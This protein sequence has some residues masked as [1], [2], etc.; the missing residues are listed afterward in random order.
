VSGSGRKRLYLLITITF[1]AAVLRGW[2]ALR[3]PTDF[4]EPVYLQ[5]AF[6]Y[7]RAIQEGDWRAVA[8]YAG[9][10]EHPALVKLLYGGVT[11]LLGPDP[12]WLAAGLANR[13][14]SALWGTVA[15]LVLSLLSPLA[16]G[17]LAAHTLTIKYTGQ[18]YLEALP[19][20]TSLVAVLAL[21]KAR[22][23]GSRWFW[24]SA[25]ALGATAAS[26]F[27]YLPVGL[28]ILY[29]ATWEKRWRWQHLLFYGAAAGA[30]FW[31]LN[32]TLWHDPL[33]RLLE[34]A[35]FHVRYS[36]GAHVQQVGYPWYQPLYW[37]SRSPP[38]LW[39]PEVFFYPGID[40]AV[41]LL[42][43]VGLNWEWK[44]RR[45]VVVWVLTSLLFLLLWPTKWPQYTLVLIPALCLS[46]G[47]AVYHGLTWLRRQ[48]TLLQWL[49]TMVPAPPRA[50]WYL[51][52][53][54]VLVIAAS[55]TVG[56]LQMTLGRL[57]WSQITAQNS[58][59]PSNLVHAIEL[60]PADQMVFATER[61][62]VMWPL[63]SATETTQNVAVWTTENSG[64]ISNRVRAVLCDQADRLWFGTEA[65]LSQLDGDVWTSFRGVDLGRVGNEIL[66]LAE[67]SQGEIWVGTG[68]GAAVLDGQSWFSYSQDSS[69]LLDNRVLSL[70]V[71]HTPAGDQVWFGA[72]GGLSRLDTATD[73]WLRFSSDELGLPW[74]GVI[75]LTV[76][77]DGNLWCGTVGGGLGLWDGS[78]WRF[79]RTSNS[80]IPFNTVNIVREV[81]PGVHWVG[82]ALPNAAGGVLAEF[83]GETWRVLNSRNSGFPE[84]EALT[85]AIDPT[86]RR[87]LGTRTAGVI[88]Y[89]PRR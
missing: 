83:N 19:H 29:L 31:L 22:T 72:P 63:E 51:S 77:S 21:V 42:G 27:T 18:V 52:G 54:L 65:G 61:G 67:G 25:V 48:D 46:A 37:I 40:G 49:K 39:H 43:L 47:S 32:P 9:N 59:L 14:L 7:A 17:L 20:L 41:A 53:S 70:A 62:V 64:L 10:R 8:D 36:Q 73:N 26:K 85:L 34:L 5:A 68:F 35:S 33:N 82:V 75:D 50:F 38:S 11:A 66:A 16:G 12:D 45:W 15:V 24:I 6:D 2:A 60:G 74:G 78:G 84:V 1:L 55:Y 4:D 81:E 44:E 79:F 56:T 57:G 58:F 87:W 89:Q 13:L 80:D 30:V 3:L 86:G 28:V 69:G 88:I 76:D 71:R 23:A